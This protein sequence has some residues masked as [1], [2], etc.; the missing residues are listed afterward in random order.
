MSKSNH[1]DVFVDCSDATL[2][3]T[4][5]F[6]AIQII[7]WYTMANHTDLLSWKKKKKSRY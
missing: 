5:Y 2:S 3:Q 1:T 7:E 6:F 4:Q